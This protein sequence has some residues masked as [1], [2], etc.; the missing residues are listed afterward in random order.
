MRAYQSVS[1][2]AAIL[3]AILMAVT[4]FAF[5]AADHSEAASDITIDGSKIRGDGFKNDAD[6]TLVVPVHS[7]L[8]NADITMIVKE[9][10]RTWHQDYSIESGWTDVKMTLRLS[11]GNHEVDIEI[12]LGGV[13]QATQS[14]TIH[15]GNN[16]W[17][18][19]STYV[20]LVVIAIIVVIIAVVYMR[21]NP[22]NKPTTTFTQLEEEKAAKAAAPAE[23]PAEKKGTDKVKYVSSRRR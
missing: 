23:A 11:E 7:D 21:A 18:N 3:L 16:V 13:T 9:G 6:G 12:T 14:Y 10:S 2:P 5:I 1:K 15:V 19:L 4:A 8:E 17:A 22:R 20:A